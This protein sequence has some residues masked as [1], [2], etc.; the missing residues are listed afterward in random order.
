[1]SK[2]DLKSVLHVH[3]NVAWLFLAC[4]KNEKTVFYEN[5]QKQLLR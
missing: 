5:N 2:H 1:M 4:V 3:L